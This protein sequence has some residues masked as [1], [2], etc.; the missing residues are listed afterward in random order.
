MTDKHQ[1][2]KYFNGQGQCIPDRQMPV[3]ARDEQLQKKLW[4]VT[5]RVIRKGV[6]K[7]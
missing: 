4:D 5:M 1:G 2:L 3:Q 6:V 7:N